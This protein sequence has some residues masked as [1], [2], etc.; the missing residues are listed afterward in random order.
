MLFLL[1]KQEESIN[2]ACLVDKLSTLSWSTTRVTL[3]NDTRTY[4]HRHAYLWPSTRVVFSGFTRR[5]K[6]KDLRSPAFSLDIRFLK[7]KT[8]LLVN[9]LED[10]AKQEGSNTETSQHH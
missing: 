1:S 4:C 3:V 2:K 7:A 6:V 10:E 5:L 9:G 8:L